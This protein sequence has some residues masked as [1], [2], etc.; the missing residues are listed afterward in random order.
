[1]PLVLG[2]MLN[3][4]CDDLVARVGVVVE[5]NSCSQFVMRRSKIIHSII[6]SSVLRWVAVLR[7]CSIGDFC[8]WRR[9]NSVSTS[10]QSI[11][12]V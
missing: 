12:S 11:Q 2:A 7:G 4:C 9:G 10:S 5:I 6:W 8:F 3:V 1:L